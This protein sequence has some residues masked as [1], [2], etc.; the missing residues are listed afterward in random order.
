VAPADSK[1]RQC[2]EFLASML[3]ATHKFTNKSTKQQGLRIALIPLFA[4]YPATLSIY[5]VV[6]Y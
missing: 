3:P 4:T 2:F 1:A 5:A 6:I